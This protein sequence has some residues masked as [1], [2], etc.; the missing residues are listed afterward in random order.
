MP[1]IQTEYAPP[2]DAQITLHYEDPDLVIVE[3]PAGLLSVPGRAP[4]KADCLEARL[5]RQL[6]EVLTVH[7][8]DMET[9]GLVVFARNAEMQKRLSNL[10]ETRKVGKT[11]LARVWGAPPE[12]GT[13]DAPLMAD[14]P[15]R[16]KQ[17]IDPN[18]KPSCTRF[19]R[20]S[21]E[22]GSGRLKLS[23]E[24]GRTHQLRVHLDHIGHPI[25]GDSLY[26]S[27]KSRSASDRLSLHASRLVFPHPATGCIID[28]ASPCPF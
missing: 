19:E 11:Y 10:F 18:G 4:E 16:P 5:R 9:S 6:P 24:T 8:L 26:G 13:I 12:Q 17:K 7:R 21:L 27:A 20:L 3:K 1:P 22:N 25:L 23:P 28:V 2:K 14:W 15:N